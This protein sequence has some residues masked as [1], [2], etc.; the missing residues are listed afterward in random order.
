[1]VDLLNHRI[2][3]KGFVHTGD[4]P[5]SDVL[6][7]FTVLEP[8]RNTAQRSKTHPPRGFDSAPEGGSPSAHKQSGESPHTQRHSVVQALAPALRN[9][10]GSALLRRRRGGSDEVGFGAQEGES[11]APRQGCH[12]RG[13]A[14]N[15]ETLTRAGGFSSA[16]NAI[17]RV[18]VCSYCPLVYGDCVLH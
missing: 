15:D 16:R 9:R 18:I 13:L 10:H 8:K 14:R 17:S 6:E 1:M 12:A 7:V 5:A 4:P 11:L 3:C 2:K